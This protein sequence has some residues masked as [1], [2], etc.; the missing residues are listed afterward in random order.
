MKKLI[1]LFTLSLLLTSLVWGA[2]YAENFDTIAN[3]GGGTAGSYNAKT[4]IN[5]ADPANDGFSSNS[6]V[7]ENSNT[8]SAGSAWRINSGAYYFRYECEETVNGFSVYLARW[9]NSPIPYFTVR[10]STNSGSD[11]TDIESLTGAW[12]TSDKGYK[13]Y[14]YTFPIAISPS[15]GNKVYIEIN[16]T[17][18]ERL[19]VDDFTLEYGSASSTPSISVIPA[20]LTGFSYDHNNGPSAEQSFTV[21]GTNL[22]AGVGIS[23][24]ADYEISLG[25]A[26]SFAPNNPIVLSPVS[27]NVESTIIYV[28]L[29][30]GLNIGLYAEQN[31]SL[32]STAAETKTVG[33][34]GSV[35]TPAAP[36]AP[37]ATAATAIYHNGFTANWDA[38]DN[39]TAYYLDVY[40]K[41]AEANAS[42]LFISEYIEGS[43]NNKAI[44][45]FNGT[46]SAVDLSHYSL[47]KQTNGAGEFV[48]EL[49]LSGTLEPNEVYVTANTS[50][51]A[52]ILALAD[53][54]NNSVT[55]FNGND[56]VA[57]YRDGVQIDMVGVVNQVADWGK[58]ITLL[59]KATVN[60]PITAYSIDDWDQYPID[61]FSYLGSHT[62]AGG[63]SNTFV[64]GYEALNVNNVITYELTGLSPETA[65]YY[66]VRA[67]DAYAQASLNSNEIEAIT[68]AAPAAY[69]Y[70]DGV[71]I[72][73][74]DILLTITGGSG[75]IVI[76]DLTPIPN[77][78][79]VIEFGQVIELLGAGP[80]T[81]NVFTL[82]PWLAYFY[83]GNWV[84]TE[85]PG[86]GNI[87]FNLD[88]PIGKNLVIELISGSGGNP[89]LPVTLSSFTAVLTADLQVKIAWISASETNHA[90]Y[91]L[92]RSEVSELATALRINSVLIDAGTAMGTETSYLYT[93]TEVNPQA[94]YYYWLESVSLNGE[95]EYYGP[96]MVL[97]NAAGE[98]PSLPEIPMQ[99][100]LFSAFPNPFNPATNLRYSLK[101]AGDVR[102]DIFNVKGQLLKSFSNTHSQPGYYQVSW[103]GRDINGHL[104]GTGLYFYRMSSGKYSSSKKMIM[105]K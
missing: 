18:G 1:F 61:T 76:R 84:V 38:V 48:N 72:D 101:A 16:K 22:T 71:Q 25:T 36:D 64:S 3:W 28:R 54:T 21:S 11:Y 69:D 80:W 53:N 52:T 43:S 95:S 8:N 10:Y 68:T 96:L 37:V 83:D 50:A 103:D 58:D 93:D 82:Q 15:S 56:A 2:T 32:S 66:V 44:E 59:R 23:A 79:F 97:I 88:Y 86:D 100:Q 6:S 85:V 77:P 57:L 47:K 45:I 30:A 14:A 74:G 34:S 27:G 62:M 33:L 55:A 99:T 40:T 35:S 41:T 31:I 70:P 87:N 65:Y 73:T 81:L 24:P 5:T 20:T 17:A 26:G 42:D 67:Y 9:D 49:I 104:V 90:G 4:Y 91:N 46:D 13:Q 78:N 63:S 75:N 39:A 102:L 60:S 89:T 51:N 94:A 98:E 19:L 7:L 92:L 12:F 105:A 29:K